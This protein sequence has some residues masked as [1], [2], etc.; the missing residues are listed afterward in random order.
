MLAK[1]WM[2]GPVITIDANDS[3]ERAIELMKDRCIKTL[4]VLK[5][6]QLVGILTD[7]D[8]KRASAS[9]ATTLSVYELIDLL[10]K[11]KVKK[12]MTKDPVTVQPDKTIGQ[13]A[14]LLRKKGISGVPVVNDQNRLVGIITKDD[15]FKVLSS[16]TGVD[17]RGIQFAFRAEDR[18]KAVMELT[19]I[20]RKYGGRVVSLYST[21]EGAPE[22]CR[23]VFI[24][25]YKV[26]R[27][28]IEW[29]KEDLEKKT[30]L[31]YMTDHRFSTGIVHNMN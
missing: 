7:R 28:Q 4:P 31:L 3:I 14:D 5:N 2:S 27:E 30:T 21:C 12:I 24:R 6:S 10:A 23:N 18:P 1:N 13:V 11:I 25:A 9:D 19:D 26:N 15:L 29:L 22:G 20:I 8:I 16:I 17:P